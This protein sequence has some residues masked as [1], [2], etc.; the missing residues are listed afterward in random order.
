MKKSR[1]RQACPRPDKAPCGTPGQAYGYANKTARKHIREGRL[2]P[3]LYVYECVCGAWHITSNPRSN[4]LAWFVP[5]PEQV[6]MM[7]PHLRPPPGATLKVD[8][9]VTLSS[10]ENRTSA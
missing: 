3:P 6:W 4:H 10:M 5:L 9:R 2:T 8:K 1:R 7:P